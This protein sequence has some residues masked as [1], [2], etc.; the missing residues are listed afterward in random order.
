[1][2]EHLIIW[3][4]LLSFFTGAAF[5]CRMVLTRS[6]QNWQRREDKRYATPTYKMLRKD[7]SGEDKMMAAMLF[8]GVVTVW[9]IVL[10]YLISADTAS[11]W[12]LAPIEKEE[13][14]E[15]QREEDLKFWRDK[16]RDGKISDE[17]RQL[18][19]MILSHIDPN[20]IRKVTRIYDP[21]EELWKQLEELHR[22]LRSS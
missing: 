13:Q 19:D 5:T 3:P 10:L 18:A 2:L 15:R 12:L 4:S 16:Y 22:N 8:T 20:H 6:Y 21:K 9:P 11:R 7:A 17:E 1:M 14:A